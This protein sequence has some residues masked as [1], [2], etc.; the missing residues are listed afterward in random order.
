[1]ARGKE[2]LNRRCCGCTRQ[3]QITNKPTRE[4]NLGHI[5]SPGPTIDTGT[6]M[7]AQYGTHLAMEAVIKHMCFWLV[8]DG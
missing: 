1:M 2:T 6:C 8:N 5:F 7:A 4:I 3:P